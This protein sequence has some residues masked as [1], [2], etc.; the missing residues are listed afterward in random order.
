MITQVIFAI[1]QTFI[2]FGVGAFARWRGMLRSEQLGMMSRFTI[3]VLMSMMVFSSVRDNLRGAGW[4]QVVV[5]PLAGFGMSALWFRAG[6]PLTSLLKRGTVELRSAFMHMSTVNNFLFLPIIIVENIW[7]G[8]H[9]AALLLMSVGF[10]VSQW[11]LGIL[12]FG[13]GSPP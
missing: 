11:T 4:D 5:P 2:A 6:W 3:N 9:V 1:A 8:A 10:T 13:C 7:G 12:P